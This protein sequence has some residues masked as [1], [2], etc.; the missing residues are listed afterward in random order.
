MGQYYKIVFLDSESRPS[1]VIDP[2]LFGY[3]LK[4]MEHSD[5]QSEVVNAVETFLRDGGRIVWAGDY[6]D[7]EP[8]IETGDAYG[9]EG[10]N[11]YF[12]TDSMQAYDPHCSNAVNFEMMPETYLINHTK[13]EYVHVIKNSE[14]PTGPHPLVLL[15]AE[16]NGRGSGDYPHENEYIGR[17]AR[18]FISVSL[19]R[20]GH[21]GP[22]GP[23]A[24]ADTGPVQLIVDF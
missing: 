21:D 8:V 22:L 2:S 16:G 3:G 19:E 24:S 7:T 9:L 13:N 1:Y 4:L 10:Q 5:L 11:L 6:A 23:F 12:L 18:D 14:G 15:T 20:P 17:W